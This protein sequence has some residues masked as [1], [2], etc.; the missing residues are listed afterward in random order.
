MAQRYIEEI[1]PVQAAAQLRQKDFAPT[2]PSALE[3]EEES[4]VRKWPRRGRFLFILGAAAACWLVPG[5]AIYWMV[6]PQ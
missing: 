5:L 3:L 6:A 4:L 1:G 2:E